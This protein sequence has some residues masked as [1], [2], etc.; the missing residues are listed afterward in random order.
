MKKFLS[1]VFL[2]CF[3]VSSWAQNVYTGFED[4]VVTFK[5]ANTETPFLPDYFGK[6][7]YHS[8]M[9]S[10]VSKY[11]ITKIERA[12]KNPNLLRSQRVYD[13]YFSDIQEVDSLVADLQK[14]SFM[15]WAEKVPIIEFF[16]TP[17][18]P[19]L[20]LQYALNRIMA[21]SIWLRECTSAE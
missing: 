12:I 8:T 10:L 18:D 7:S 14:Y 17:D 1:L 6:G 13:V 2:V 3:T 11:G 4:G 21:D 15:E 5:L 19:K 9:D 20:S 16:G